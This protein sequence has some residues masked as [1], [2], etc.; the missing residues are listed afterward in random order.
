MRTPVMAGNWKMYKT[1][2][3][4]GDTIRTL[5]GLV[6]GVSGVE[7]VIC[8][9]FTALAAAI[10]AAKGSCV[11]IG[12]Q[13]CYWEKEGAFTGQV[14]VPM[15]ADLGCSQCIVGHFERRQ[16]FGETDATVDKKV[17]PVM[18]QGLS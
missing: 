17:G 1:A 2:R 7:V 14:A 6:A 5:T 8:A 18:A 13:D 12:A 11:A 10:E 9:P 4:A 16:F 15:L 3:Q